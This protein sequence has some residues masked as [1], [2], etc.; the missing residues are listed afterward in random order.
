MRTALGTV[1]VL[2]LTL[3]A[4]DAPEGDYLPRNVDT[5]TARSATVNGPGAGR[6]EPSFSGSEAFP[7]G[8]HLRQ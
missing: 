7:S 8:K 2:S 1:F 5:W 3:T 4:C 6:S